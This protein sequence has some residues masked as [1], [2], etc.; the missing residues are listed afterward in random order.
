[1]KFYFEGFYGDPTTNMDLEVSLMLQINNV[2]SAYNTALVNNINAVPDQC[3]R[4]I[5]ADSV[6]F[7]VAMS[8]YTRGNK[9]SV[10]SALCCTHEL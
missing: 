5:F 10:C 2:K 4:G 9:I 3:K 6:I 7:T 1:M 8:S